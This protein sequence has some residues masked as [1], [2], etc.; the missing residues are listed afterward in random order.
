MKNIII[1]L[2]SVFISVSISFILFTDKEKDFIDLK[3]I[4]QIA[5]DEE[6][7][8]KI[9]TFSGKDLELLG[10]NVIINSGN[11]KIEFRVG[12]SNKIIITRD[13]IDI[14]TNNLYINPL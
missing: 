2:I 3:D 5:L 14:L 12:D 4:G 7:K 6:N 8:L 13:R 9:Q 11:E 1:I 10:N